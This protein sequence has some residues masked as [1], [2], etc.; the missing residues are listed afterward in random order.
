MSNCLDSSS[1]ALLPFKVTVQYKLRTCTFQQRK[2]GAATDTHREA[3]ISNAKRGGRTALLSRT[4][5]CLTLGEGWV[6]NLMVYMIQEFHITSINSALI[7]NIV[8][9]FVNLFPVLGAIIADSFLGSFQ[10]IWI[11]SFISLLGTIL[12]DSTATFD[13]L[14]PQR[15]DIGLSLCKAPSKVQFAVLYSGIALACLGLGGLR[16]TLATMG[17]NQ[18]E[19][20]Q[21]QGIFFNWFFILTYASTVISSAAFVYIEDN[22]SWRLGSGLNIAANLA[23]VDSS[24][25]DSTQINGVGHVLNKIGMVVSSV[26]ESRRL[27]IAYAH[28]LQ[29]QPGS[30]V[31]MLALWLFPQLVL[32]GIGEAFHFPGQVQLYYQEF[33][34][35]LRGTATSMITLILGIGLCLST[36]LIDIVRK[37][38]GY[39]LVCSWNY[40]YRNV[41]KEVDNDSGFV[42]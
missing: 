11:S 22:L 6:A 18:F 14:R 17:A 4:V 33:P 12:L 42:K 37:A 41:E 27:K 9:G 5:T 20:P 7:S 28:H 10:V 23:D 40:R 34:A 21:H 25:A 38:T 32:V 1:T 31:P 3:Q 24:V 2:L 30:L 35:S 15:C 19:I 36:A 39:Y 8:N 29:D 26:V 16:F 13:S